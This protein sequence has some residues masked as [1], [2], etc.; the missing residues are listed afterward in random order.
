[1]EKFKKMDIAD[2]VYFK[3]K[4]IGR[5]SSDS[6]KDLKGNLSEAKVK[7]EKLEREISTS[8]MELSKYQRR[9][10]W[11]NWFPIKIFFKKSIPLKQE[12]I[13]KLKSQLAE[14]KSEHDR[15]K[16][17]IEICLSDNLDAAFGTLSDIYLRLSAVSR[18]W[19]MTTSQQVDRVAMRTMANSTCERK[20]VRFKGSKVEIIQCD[21]SALFMENANGEDLYLFPQFLFM[22]S[23]ADFALIDIADLSIEYSQCNFIEEEALP[24]DTEVIGQAWA[25]ANKDGSRDKRFND[26]Y[27][28]PIAKYGEL[29]LKTNSGLNEVYLF[30]NSEP[31]FEFKCMFDEYRAL[32]VKA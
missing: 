19:D 26:N 6:L 23:A 5:L 24:G 7:K 14:L 21:Y 16:V 15:C 11:I 22:Q 4:I 17:G 8:E 9:L 31:A 25:K 27:Q 1:M 29:H 2:K 3:S 18:I 13:E 12:H 32:L 20:P 30:S 28:I 10:S